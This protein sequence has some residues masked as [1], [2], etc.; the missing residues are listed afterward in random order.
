MIMLTIIASALALSI[1]LAIGY[2]VYHALEAWKAIAEVL[3]DML[4]L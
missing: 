2:L 1:L 4:S 3:N